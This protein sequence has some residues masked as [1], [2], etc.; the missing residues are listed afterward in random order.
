M[1]VYRPDAQSARK[2]LAMAGPVKTTLKKKFP[3]V[4]SKNVTLIRKKG[5]EVQENGIEEPIML[6][7]SRGSLEN[8]PIW[9]M[10]ILSE[11]V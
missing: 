7:S 9:R 3:M 4:N 5:A 11:V 2:R 10:K 1:L 8:V 6:I